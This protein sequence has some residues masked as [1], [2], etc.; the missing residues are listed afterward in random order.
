MK[1]AGGQPQTDRPSSRPSNKKKSEVT[2]ERILDEALALF[3][4][5]GFEKTTMREVA[6]AASLAPGA[7]YYYFPSKEAIL[8][9]YYARNQ[10]Q[11]ELRVVGRL[12][13]SLRDKLSLVFHEKLEAVKRER[14]LLGA[15]IQRL[16]DPSD[17]ISAFAKE[18]RE[19]RRLSM[20][21]FARAL[22]DEPLSDELKRLLEPA[23]WLLHL[24]F[25][26]YFIHDRSAQQDKT[27]RLVD[28]ML[29]LLMPLIAVGGHAPHLITQLLRTLGHAG[30]IQQT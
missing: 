26:L 11:H 19:V 2:R 8:L 29:D 21:L 20:A 27:H 12:Q 7:A 24:G 18:T 13:G 9:A 28:E 14:K 17:P 30:L 6:E 4:K 15:V 22:K 23:L 10:S 16:A 5:K 3:R 25:M 1:R